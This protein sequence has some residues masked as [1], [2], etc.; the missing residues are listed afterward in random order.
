VASVIPD[1][2]IDACRQSYSRPTRDFEPFAQFRRD[3]RSFPC[4]YHIP[5]DADGTTVV[6]HLG[7]VL[8]EF[9]MSGKRLPGLA[10]ATR[11]KRVDQRV[12]AGPSDDDVAALPHIEE[13][14]WV[15]EFNCAGLGLRAD[16]W[17]VR[18]VNKAHVR[19]GLMLDYLSRDCAYRLAHQR[20]A[21]PD[22]AVWEVYGVDPIRIALEHGAVPDELDELL[23]E[24]GSKR[25]SICPWLAE[26]VKRPSPGTRDL[27]SP[28]GDPAYERVEQV[29]ASL[30]P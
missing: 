3:G 25:G 1:E 5:D 24:L 2:L 27:I 19:Y 17:T 14:F 6:E 8:A 29:I 4:D 15:A 9:D 20:D 26:A 23:S 10:H 21:A 30:S 16:T 12:F 18:G 28:A 11:A 22:T 13:A 7:A